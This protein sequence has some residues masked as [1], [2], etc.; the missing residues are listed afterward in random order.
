MLDRQRA[1]SR[2][3]SSVFFDIEGIVH[4]GFILAG[5]AVISAYYYIL[6]RLRKNVRRLWP[7]LGNKELAVES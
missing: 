6:Q 4:K 2:A 1:K 5:Q 3:C 7:E